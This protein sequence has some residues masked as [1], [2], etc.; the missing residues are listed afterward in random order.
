MKQLSLSQFTLKSKSIISPDKFVF[1]SGTSFTF[2][3]SLD[4]LA[5]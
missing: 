5:K 1:A 3:I 2:I 4:D